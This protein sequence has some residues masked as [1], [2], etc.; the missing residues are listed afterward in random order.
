MPLL[1]AARSGRRFE[2]EDA[3]Q[4]QSVVAEGQVRLA[5]ELATAAAQWFRDSVTG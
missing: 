1:C 4:V 3:D 5:E 2:A